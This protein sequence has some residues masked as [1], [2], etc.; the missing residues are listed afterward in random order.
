MATA[1]RWVACARLTASIFLIGKVVAKPLLGFAGATGSREIFMA[2]VILLV[3]VKAALTAQA[4]LNPVKERFEEGFTSIIPN[5]CFAPQFRSLKF[6][7]GSPL[8]DCPD[9]PT[10]LAFGDDRF[11]VRFREHGVSDRMTEV[12]AQ[13]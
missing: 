1:L 5:V 13:S 4:G 8:A 3:L 12:R 6:R 11:D 7:R 10:L 2:A 9:R